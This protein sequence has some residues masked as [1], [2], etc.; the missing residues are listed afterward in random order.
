MSFEAALRLTEILFALAVIQQSAEHLGV[1]GS[2]RA[3]LGLR[4]WLCLGLAFGIYPAVMLLGLLGIAVWLLNC[5]AGPYNGGSD[6]MTLLVLMCLVATHLAPS[7]TLQELALGYLSVQLV[8]SY[9]VSGWVKLKNPDW[10]DGMALADVFRFSAYPVSEGLR[11]NADR[12]MLVLIASWAVIGFEVL[13][14]LVLLSSWTLAVGLGIA[15]SFHFANACLFG[16]NRFFWIWLS[17]YPALI[18]FQD[19]LFG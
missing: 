18:W 7:K 6:R 17:A 16:L 1:R 4:I 8:L 15:A 9:A 19:R 11:A 10:R 12:R 14:P 5:Y 3:V 2:D 13:F